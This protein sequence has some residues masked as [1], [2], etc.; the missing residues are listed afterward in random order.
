MADVYWTSRLAK[1]LRKKHAIE[2][3]EDICRK[4]DQCITSCL[5]VLVLVIFWA[6]VAELLVFDHITYE[7]SG[8]VALGTMKEV[9][10]SVS[11][12][13]LHRV[14]QVMEENCKSNEVVLGCQ[15]LLSGKPFMY[16]IMSVCNQHATLVNPTI[17]VQGTTAG[18]CIENYN[19][20]MYKKM[21]LFPLTL[22]SKNYI[23]L[24]LLTIEDVCPVMTAL[25]I[26]NNN[27]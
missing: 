17:A 5:W 27:T 19:S 1:T 4:H 8:E 16:R 20:E 22:H 24:T 21:R 7:F 3:L 13:Q 2:Q 10:S 15:V 12:R 18:Y 11:K 23:P 25:D 9:D 14:M 6:G 26:I